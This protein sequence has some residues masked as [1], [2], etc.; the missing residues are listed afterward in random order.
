M[1][2]YFSSFSYLIVVD[3]YWLYVCK[4]R[5]IFVVLLVGW[6]TCCNEADKWRVKSG[7]ERK[8][9]YWRYVSL[10]TFSYKFIIHCIWRTLTFFNKNKVG[11]PW[12]YASRA[13]STEY[14]F[15]F[16]LKNPWQIHTLDCLKYLKIIIIH[17]GWLAFFLCFLDE[18][19]QEPWT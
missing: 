15:N 3:C 14:F 10:M 2:K 9:H 8:V 5:S 19:G 1:S 11:A 7:S 12:M 18:I 17:K 16:F 4:Y 13:H 6:T